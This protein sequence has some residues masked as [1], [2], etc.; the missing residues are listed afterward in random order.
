MALV[1]NLPYNCNRLCS[2][3][4]RFSGVQSLKKVSITLCAL[5]LVYGCGAKKKAKELEDQLF[6][7]APYE[8]VKGEDIT[9]YLLL[10][11]GAA[12]VDTKAAQATL[13]IGA[14]EASKDNLS[15]LG[16]TTSD[17]EVPEVETSTVDYMKSMAAKKY[18]FNS[19]SFK[20]PE[21]N[22]LTQEKNRNGQKFALLAEWD[23]LP[24]KEPREFNPQ[25]DSVDLSDAAWGGKTEI[26]ISNLNRISIKNQG[27][28]GTC[29][30]FTGIA[31]LEYL[32]LKKHGSELQGVD[33]SEQRFYML[34][35]SDLWS[36]GGGKVDVDGGSAW[37]SGYRMSFADE[38]KSPPTDTSPYNIPIEEDCPYAPEPGSNELQIPQAQSCKRGAIKVRSLTRTYDVSWTNGTK[39]LYSNSVRSAQEI[40]NY[41]KTYDL[42]VPVGTKLTDNW[43]NND[44]MITLAK[45]KQGSTPHAGGHAYLIVGMRKLNEAD[46]PGEGGMCFVIRNSWGTGWGVQG[47]SCMTL[48]WFNEYRDQNPYDYVTDVDLDLAYLKSKFQPPVGTPS[49]PQGPVVPSPPTPEPTP[50]LIDVA[51]P[52]VPPNPPSPSAPVEIP[53]P[54]PAPATTGDGYTLA[55]L[56]TKDGGYVRVQYKVAE[57]KISLR[58]QHPQAQTVTQSIDLNYEASV[59]SY[60]DEIRG[61]KEVK[62]GEIVGDL[63]YLCSGKYAIVCA[64]NYLKESNELVLGISESEFR[65][66]EADPDADYE[67]LVKFAQ[68]GIEYHKAAGIFTDIRFVIKDKPTNPLRLAVKPIGGDVMMAGQ[69]VGNYQKAAFC[70]GDYRSVCRVVFDKK[71][72]KVE[73]FLKAKPAS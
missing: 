1:V 3:K 16:L 49:A 4:V 30:A 31:G 23:G 17:P 29:A 37:E 6:A 11:P 20:V 47:I 40:F 46:F 44:G 36:A 13:S 59:M 34:S 18:G 64:F 25:N 48:A 32:I 73:V 53:A 42:P 68:Y 63:V 8:P 50:K 69:V 55:R 2:E 5:T 24:K 28:R 33:L 71:N 62:V 39:E 12:P 45:A 10:V 70:S 58:G 52:G 7:E 22:K 15:L 65:R 61:K 38:G 19:A 51:D 21:L 41:I 56:V 67:P 9:K 35:R 27:A 54:T 66:Y 26:V 57:G 14:T 43:E 72:N 60:R